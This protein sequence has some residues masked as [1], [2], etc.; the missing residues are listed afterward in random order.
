MEK[1]TWE[2][3]EVLKKSYKKITLLKET[4]KASSEIKA[5]RS[6]RWRRAIKASRGRSLTMEAR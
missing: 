1:G 6:R 5:K 2:T 4:T 3:V